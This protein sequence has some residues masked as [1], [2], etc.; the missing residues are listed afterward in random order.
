M[1]KS[2]FLRIVTFLLCLALGWQFWKGILALEPTQII[3]GPAAHYIESAAEETGATNIVAA[4]LFDYRALD[5][6]G[7]ASVIYTSVCGIAM[8]FAKSKFKISSTGLSFI[9][10]KGVSF[11]IPFLL[12]YAAGI[13]LM[14]H[15]SPGGGFQGGAVF[16]TATILFCIV[17]GSGFEAVMIKPKTKELIESSGALMFVLIGFVGLWTGAGF[18]SNIAA[19][20]PKGEVGRF[21]SGGSI[22]LLNIAIG[23]KVSAGLSTIFY[24]MIKLLEFEVTK[25]PGVKNK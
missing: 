11:I 14:G 13:V 12:L 3:I 15:I 8:L 2:C 24:S 25:I 17:Y 9:V 21:L 6:L 18:L 1:S 5:T 10:K 20:Y 4:I 22:P 23:M 7:E 19:G 16:A